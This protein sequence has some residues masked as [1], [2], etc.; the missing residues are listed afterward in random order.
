M[1]ILK[2]HIDVVIP[3]GPDCVG[4]A[5]GNQTKLLRDLL[6]RLIDSKLTPT[7]AK[8]SFKALQS[9]LDY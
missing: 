1:A 8:V 4:T 9:L 2:V 3:L 6:I 5:C 7:M